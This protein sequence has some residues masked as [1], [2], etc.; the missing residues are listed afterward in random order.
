M[1]TNQNAIN[2]YVFLPLYWVL[3]RF[4]NPNNSG[5]HTTIKN[6]IEEEEG[7]EEDLGGE[8]IGEEVAEVE[9]VEEEAEEEVEEIH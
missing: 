2:S 5:T 9:E 3:L 4:I 1:L 8:G 7:W 6:D